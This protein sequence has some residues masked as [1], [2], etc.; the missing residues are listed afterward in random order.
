M[1]KK[2][3]ITQIYKNIIRLNWKMLDVL[4]IIKAGDF[5]TH[6]RCCFCYTNFEMISL[7]PIHQH[8]MVLLIAIIL[9]SRQMI[10]SRFD[11]GMPQTFHDER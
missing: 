5:N 8:L 9:K 11:T 7:Q 1:R 6:L 2:Y 10:H 4:E 3:R